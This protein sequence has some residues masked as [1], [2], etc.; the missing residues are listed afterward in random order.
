MIIV[1]FEVL[2]PLQDRELRLLVHRAADEESGASLD[3]LCATNVSR[4]GR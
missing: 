4:C 1:D 2:L 3:R